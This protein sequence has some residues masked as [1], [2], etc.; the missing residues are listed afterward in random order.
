[1]AI[2]GPENPRSPNQF[3]LKQEAS[4]NIS[5]LTFR[6]LS[7]LGNTNEPSLSASKQSKSDQVPAFEESSKLEC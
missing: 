2:M 7:G 4:T 6:C 3:L 5:D 1:M